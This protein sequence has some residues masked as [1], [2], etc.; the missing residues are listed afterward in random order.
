MNVVRVAF[1][2]L[3]LSS[4][5][6]VLAQPIKFTPP[7]L[8]KAELSALPS[9]M[10]VGGGEVLIEGIV[11]R[12]GR[13]TRPIVLRGTPPYTQL[14]LDAIA[15]WRF[16]PARATG[17]DGLEAIVEMP[18]AIAGVYRPPILMNAPTLGEPPKDVSKPSGDVAYPTSMQMPNYPPQARDAG[19]V[20]FE[21]VL[22]EAGGITETRGIASI[23]G[24]ETASREALA[25]WGFRGGSFRARPVPTTAYVMFGFSS[26][27]VTS[28]QSRPP[29]R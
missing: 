27:V 14:V 20:L 18:V 5:T 17:A 12:A 28:P 25:R 10:V 19:V 21:V 13:L 23:G 7:R 15:M 2:T 3:A 11:D 1:A 26:P 24:F 22:N 16:E 29:T 8:L 4:A 9:P 6:T